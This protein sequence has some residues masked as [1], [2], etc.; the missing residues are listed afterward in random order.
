MVFMPCCQL[1]SWTK[2]A[3]WTAALSLYKNLSSDNNLGLFGLKI[4]WDLARAFLMYAKLTVS[5]LKLLK[6]GGNSNPFLCFCHFFSLTALIK[7][8]SLFYVILFSPYTL[9]TKDFF[10][11]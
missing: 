6:S 2:V 11:R 8:F 4:S 1:K 7:E 9:F 3:A 10:S 5:L